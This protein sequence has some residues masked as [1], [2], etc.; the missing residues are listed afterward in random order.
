MERHNLLYPWIVKTLKEKPQILK[1][2]EAAYFYSDL[3]EIWLSDVQ[4]ALKD[5]LSDLSEQSETPIEK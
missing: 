5:A 2:K 4:Q 1:N 3:Y